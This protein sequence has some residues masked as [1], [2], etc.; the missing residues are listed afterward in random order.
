MAL[1]LQGSFQILLWNEKDKGQDRDPFLLGIHENVYNTC[2]HPTRA[3]V[4]TLP[5]LF[6]GKSFC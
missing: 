5:V 2:F 4:Q 1:Q 3:K 6:P